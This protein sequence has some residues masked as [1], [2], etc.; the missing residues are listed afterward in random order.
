MR[1]AHKSK[2][3]RRLDLAAFLLAPLVAIALIFVLDTGPL[4]AWIERHKDSKL[5]EAIVIGVLLLIGVSVFLV[6]RSL[7][8]SNRLKRIASDVTAS[9]TDRAKDR[10][11]RD[12]AGI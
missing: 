9:F 11:R 12:L 5:D 7:G 6:S 4:V 2:K 8:L 3:L 1:E 10:L